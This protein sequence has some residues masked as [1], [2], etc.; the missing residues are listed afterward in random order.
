MRY[1]V[2]GFAVAYGASALR[3]IYLRFKWLIF[4][5]A[6]K[7]SPVY[8]YVFFF[9]LWISKF[10]F[11]VNVFCFTNYCIFV[12]RLHVCT[13]TKSFVAWCVVPFC[14]GRCA[15]LT[16]QTTSTSASSTVGR[17]GWSLQ[18][19]QAFTVGIL[20]F[21]FHCCSLYDVRM[22]LA[23]F[24]YLLV[25]VPRLFGSQTGKFCFFFCLFVCL[26][27]CL[28]WHFHYVVH[29][30]RIV[31]VVLLRAQPTSSSRQSPFRSPFFFLC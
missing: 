25:R 30:T 10:L 16:A 19:I 31:Y 21:F 18:L 11:H 29:G 13:R 12:L 1:I 2:Y 8:V 14:L 5:F 27:V 3:P 28:F 7:V 17:W 4:G 6:S 20:A 23:C 26:F 15:P 9:K 24:F 22:Y